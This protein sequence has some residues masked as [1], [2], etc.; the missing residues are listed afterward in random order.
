M[1]TRSSIPIACCL[2]LA[3]GCGATSNQTDQLPP[4]EPQPSAIVAPHVVAEVAAVDNLE[5]AFKRAIAKADP[6]VVSVYSSKTVT[7]PGFGMPFGGDPWLDRLF[8]PQA[9][10]REF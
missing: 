8:P 7:L 3:L 1:S 9:Q 4:V 10:P 6:A 2:A 5:S